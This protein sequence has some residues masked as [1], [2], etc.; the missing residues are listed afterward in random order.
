[1]DFKKKIKSFIPDKC[2]YMYY[3]RLLNKRK[4]KSYAKIEKE[5][6]KDYKQINKRNI[7]WEN[8]QSYTEKINVSKLYCEN[9]LKT[10]LTDKIS[11][12][13]WIKEKIGE[14]YLIP[15]LGV[16]E[17]FSDI[18]FDLLPDKFVIKCN[19]DS[20]S[21]TLCD[22]KSN[23]NLK[24]LKDK[25][26]YYMSRNFAYLGYE[27]H[28]KNIVPKIL[29]EEYM[30]SAI[31]DYKFLCFNGKPYYCWVDV[32]RFGKHKRNVYDMDWNLQPFEQMNYGNYENELK[33][34]KQFEKMKEIV[35][36]LCQGF[37]HVRV[38]LYIVNDKIYFGEM[39]FTNGSG[40]EKITPEK[41]DYE[42]GKLWKFNVD[43]RDM[44]I[45]NKNI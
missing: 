44:K 41:Y 5:I 11:V 33:C 6:N 45:N 43:K 29:I 28:Y 27:M 21:V 36:K 7:N 3:L 37:D 39:T 23:L 16:Y 40:F 26:D 42:L 18:N 12:R 25:Y 4:N 31:N 30:G 34:P 24:K 38:D 9:D 15:I 17:K 22:N 8:P 20:G 19:H 2:M 10:Q 13:E 1:M 32:D 35:L 14:E